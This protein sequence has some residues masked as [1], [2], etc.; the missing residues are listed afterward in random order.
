ME[1]SQQLTKHLKM[2]TVS[3]AKLVF[4]GGVQLI[5]QG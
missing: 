3:G 1:L 5:E 2:A 4:F